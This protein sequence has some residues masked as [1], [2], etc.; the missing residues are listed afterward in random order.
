MLDA[1]C[2]SGWNNIKKHFAT[3]QKMRTFVDELKPNL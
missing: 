2:W 3:P 1:G